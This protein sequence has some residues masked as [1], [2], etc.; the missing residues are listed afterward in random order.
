MSNKYLEK[1]AADYEG[2]FSRVNPV[3]K[4]SNA[5]ANAAAAAA[6]PGITSI[7]NGPASMIGSAKHGLPAIQTK[8][9]PRMPLMSRIGQFIGRNK[10]GLLAGAALGATAAKLTQKPAQPSQQ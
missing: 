10:V 4:V 2:E 1:I 5:S 9:V 6:K 3:A 8:V 7:P